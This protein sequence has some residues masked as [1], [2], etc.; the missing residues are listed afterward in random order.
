[1]RKQSESEEDDGYAVA[2]D[3]VSPQAE[4]AVQ[5]ADMHG[6]TAEETGATDSEGYEQ[7]DDFYSPQPT[8][9]NNDD[10]YGE[11]PGFD[12]GLPV[13]EDQIPQRS[14]EVSVTPKPITKPEPAPESADD[15]F[16][17]NF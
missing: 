3:F 10:G 2:E 16:N 8:L 7:A 15:E 12:S 9:S 17:F 14:A 1:M 11:I 6:F 5:Y 4:A 13:V